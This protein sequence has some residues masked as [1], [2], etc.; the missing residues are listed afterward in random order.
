MKTAKQ[1][2]A[3]I[4]SVL[5][6]RLDVIERETWGDGTIITWLASPFPY[7]R[8]PVVPSSMIRTA[9]IAS[10]PL[11]RLEGSQKRITQVGLDKHAHG[12][13]ADDMPLV[14]RGASGRLYIADGHHRLAA[15]YVNGRDTAKVRLVDIGELG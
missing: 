10:V 9:K 4:N 6:R 2:D 12:Y 13:S 8:K 14:F 3:E 7:T 15:A 5:A 11:S 1:I